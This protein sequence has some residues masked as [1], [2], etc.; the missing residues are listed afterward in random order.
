MN[1]VGVFANCGIPRLKEE[2]K[3]I[4]ETFSILKNKYPDF[5]KDDQRK[6]VF[7][8]NVRNAMVLFQFANL[9]LERRDLNKKLI[10]LNSWQQLL[11]DCKIY[12]AGMKIT[13]L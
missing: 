11:Q 13:G 5:R 10:C 4:N 7:F 6:M 3:K 9:M 2:L 12:I 8:L 1:K